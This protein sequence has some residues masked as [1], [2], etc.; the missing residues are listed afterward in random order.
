MRPPAALQR[1]AQ[2][3]PDSPSRPPGGSLIELLRLLGVTPDNLAQASGM[4]WIRP[5][6]GDL[7]APNSDQKRVEPSP[8]LTVR[9]A[10]ERA[11]CGPK[12]V[13]REAHAGKLRAARVGGRR[14]LRFR[15]AWID[16][17][18]ERGS[19]PVDVTP[20]VRGVL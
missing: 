5:L 19:R 12:T 20:S 4:D 8:W 14:D 18:L 10:A 17:W 11:R 13:Y 15:A 7:R 9:E 3:P 2:A 16:E 1:P 6:E